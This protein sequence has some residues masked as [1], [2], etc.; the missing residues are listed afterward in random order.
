M[1]PDVLLRFKGQYK[2]IGNKSVDIVHYFTHEE[3][4]VPTFSAHSVL[5]LRS[6]SRRIW[7]CRSCFSSLSIMNMHAYP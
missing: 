1:Y 4:A 2:V 3:T 7:P 5:R 6:M